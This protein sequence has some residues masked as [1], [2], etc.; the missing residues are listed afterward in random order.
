MVR[1]SEDLPLFLDCLKDPKGPIVDLKTPVDLST[2]KYF[3]MESDFSGLT[4]PLDIDIKNSL[5]DVA[6]KFKAKQVKIKKL[7]F[8]LDISMS[9][10]LRLKD[11]ETIYNKCGPGEKDKTT[12]RELLKYFAGMSDSIFPSVIMSTLQF[13]TAKC[14]PQVR[15][16]QLDR[17][18]K[19]LQDEFKNLLGDNGVFFYPTFPNSAHHHYKI[20]HKLVDTTYM[21]VFNTL[22]MPATQVMTGFDR[23]GLPIGIQVSD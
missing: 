3:Y 7:K 17:I 14:V 8:S 13:V 21:M 10:M 5:L 2:L 15:H 12:G 1:Y 18:T 11:V 22:G 23:H 16:R 4:Q 6:K 19:E 20:Y 9:K